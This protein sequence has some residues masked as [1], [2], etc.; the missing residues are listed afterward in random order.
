MGCR[1]PHRSPPTFPPHHALRILDSYLAGS[2][3]SAIGSPQDFRQCYR[4]ALDPT[5]P[6]ILQ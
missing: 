1:P 2:T 5:K 4:Y 3:K 6:G